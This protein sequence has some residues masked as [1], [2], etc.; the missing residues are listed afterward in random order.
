MLPVACRGKV[1]SHHRKHTHGEGHGHVKATR[2]DRYSRTEACRGH[3]T[4]RNRRRHLCTAVVACSTRASASTS[5][6]VCQR[7]DTSL[8]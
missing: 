7:E 1:R 8:L 4:A 2:Q 5:S 6:L 3:H